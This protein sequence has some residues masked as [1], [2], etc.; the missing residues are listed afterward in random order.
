[1]SSPTPPV[2]PRTPTINVPGS[3]QGL[4]PGDPR[5][6]LPP[7]INVPGSSQGL[8]PGD[9]QVRLDAANAQL[10]KAKADIVSLQARKS[11]LKK[12]NAKDKKAMAAYRAKLAQYDLQIQKAK[13]TVA[14]LQRQIPDLQNRVYESTG[15]YDK[16]LTGANRDAFMALQSIFN[17][18]GL[19]S[20]A[21]KIYEMVK[22]GES[23]DT[24]SIQ[25]QDTDEYKKRFAGNEARKKNGLPVYS[26][27]E[28]LSIESS[29][30][31]IMRS[32]GFPPGF[33]DTRQDF[34][35][36]IGRN[37]SPKEIQDRVDLATQAAILSNPQY[38]AALNQMGIDNNHLA[39]YFLDDKRALPYLQ[40]AAATAQVGAEA[41]RQNLS[42]DQAYAEQLATQG[43]SADQARQGYE[44]IASSLDTLRALGGIYGE[45]W[46]QRTSEEATFGTSAAAVKKQ[47]RLLSQE[48]GAF[49]GAAGGARA[50][51]GGT[52][53]QR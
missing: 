34:A 48:R 31:Q 50:G 19:G 20:L 53:G 30:D 27:A 32:S 51:L 23:A 40:K 7:R 16:L 38:R 49:S 17:S 3:S 44:Q 12:P 25:L 33:Y 2:A 1:M 46:T 22:N 24:I 43:V 21:P 29:F 4:S 5:A 11:Y 36:W 15:Q 52:G 14:T 42:F 47:G 8:N 6:G 45:E 28:Y 18:Y 41:L 13:V 35:D 10:K 39:A 37:I 9:P 26:A